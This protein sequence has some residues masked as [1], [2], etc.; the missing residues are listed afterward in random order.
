MA[1][2]LA[3]EGSAV[4]VLSRIG[5]GRVERMPGGRGEAAV[6]VDLPDLV[7]DRRKLGVPGNAAKHGRRP[8]P[9]RLVKPVGDWQVNARVS[10]GG[11]A[12]EDAILAEAN[13]P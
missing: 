6:V 3:H 9:D 10:I 13:S 5:P 2:W 4:P 1:R 12:E 11:G 8:S 7:G